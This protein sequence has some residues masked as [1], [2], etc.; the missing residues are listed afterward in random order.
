MIIEYHWILY[1]VLKMLCMD[2]WNAHCW[3]FMDILYVA[4]SFGAAKCHESC[5]LPAEPVATALLEG[6]G[7]RGKATPGRVGSTLV[8][9]FCCQRL[10]LFVELAVYVWLP[11]HFNSLIILNFISNIVRTPR[12]LSNIF[13]YFVDTVHFLPLQNISIISIQTSPNIS[14]DQGGASAR[15]SWP[16][17][18]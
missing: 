13:R 1:D 2:A 15:W 7:F 5:Y 3:T 14:I 9:V 4:I 11:L 10:V 6:Y 17:W 18:D 12:S 16:F 8:V